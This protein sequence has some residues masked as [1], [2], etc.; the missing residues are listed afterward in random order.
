MSMPIEMKFQFN[1]LLNLYR[2]DL[3]A[4]NFRLNFPGK[5][6]LK[7]LV[8]NLLL[9]CSSKGNH[10]KS[11]F[12]CESKLFATHALCKLFL[13]TSIRWFVCVL[14]PLTATTSS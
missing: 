10:Q 9:I 8:K 14:H 2:L 11:K 1:M 7:Q 3:L 6:V 4:F 5:L 13:L 12:Q